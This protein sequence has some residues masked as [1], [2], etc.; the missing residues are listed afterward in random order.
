[1]SADLLI[2]VKHLRKVYGKEERQTVALDDVSFSMNSGDFVAMMGPSGSG[3]STLL[4]LLGLL[5]VPSAGTYFFEGKETT[6]YSGKQLA[7]IR[8]EKMGFVFQAFNLLPKTSV[9]DNVVLPLLYSKIPSSHWKER[10]LSAVDSVGLHHRLHHESGMLSGG[11]K[12]RCAIARA[13][14]TDP[15]IIFADEPTGNLD[16][17][18][19]QNIM[20]ILR[21]LHEKKRHTILL[22]THEERIAQYAER[23]ITVRDGLIERDVL[24]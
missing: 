6:H 2:D 21:G 9:Y 15:A 12:Q 14:V 18:S 11:E 8:N 23:I 3:K 22:I 4:Q 16:S 7:R 20:E 1:M 10:V 19:G 5:D 13:L 24:L 17:K